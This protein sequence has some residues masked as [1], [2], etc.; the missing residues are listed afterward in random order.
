MKPALQCPLC[1]W[2][3]VRPD[4]ACAQG[5]PLGKWCGLVRCPSCGYEFAEPRPFR[6]LARLFHRCPAPAA[7]CERLDLTQLAEGEEA[8]VVSLNCAHPSRRNTLAVYGVAPGHRVVLQ[9]HRPHVI[10]RV[11]ETELAL[12]TDIAREIVVKRL[13]RRVAGGDDRSL[14]APRRSS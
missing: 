7:R 5:C 6:W 3:F 4:T 8:E 1:H 10:L 12:E 11:G 9:Q 13:T 2:E 14:D